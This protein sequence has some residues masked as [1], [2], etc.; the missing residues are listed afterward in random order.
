MDT[1]VSSRIETG[2]D[3]VPS[4][5]SV[6]ATPRL[7]QTVVT[8]STDRL[9]MDLKESIYQWAEKYEDGSVRDAVER[10]KMVMKN[11]IVKLSKQEMIILNRFSSYILQHNIKTDNFFYLFDMVLKP[12]DVLY[13]NAGYYLPESGEQIKIFCKMF[14][15]IFKDHIQYVNNLFIVEDVFPQN[16]VNGKAFVINTREQTVDMTLKE[17]LLVVKVA[18]TPESD[19]L[20]YEYYIGRFLNIMRFMGITDVFALMYGRFTCDFN[21]DRPGDKLCT[22]KS[23]DDKKKIHIITEYVRNVSTG[24]SLSLY[25][26]INKRF[27]KKD[28]LYT[29]IYKYLLETNLIVKN[30]MMM[31]LVS[32]QRA[33]DLM[34]FTHYDLHLGNILIVEHENARKYNTGADYFPAVK[35]MPHII[36]YGR[37]YIDTSRVLEEYKLL[38]DKREVTYVDDNEKK[39]TSF[40][41]IQKEIYENKKFTSNNYESVEIMV[42]RYISENI[43]EYINVKYKEEIE[44][45]INERKIHYKNLLEQEKD[46]QKKILE[47]IYEENISKDEKENRKRILKYAMYYGP[48][49][50]DKNEIYDEYRK[51]IYNEYRN[52]VYEKYV[53]SKKTGINDDQKKKFFPNGDTLK[54]GV[55]DDIY[56]LVITTPT[57]PNYQHDMFK[58]V[59]SICNHM[60]SRIEMIFNKNIL[61]DVEC[62]NLA[63][64]WIE[65]KAVLKQEFPIYLERYTL[66]FKEIDNNIKSP[67]MLVN[68]LNNKD[69]VMTGGAKNS[70]E[71]DIKKNEIKTESEND[72]KMHQ[73]KDVKDI[74]KM[75]Y[76]MVTEDEYKKYIDKE[77][78]KMI[79]EK[80]GTQMNDFDLKVESELKKIFKKK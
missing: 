1:M 56:E 2:T 54:Y 48:F 31:I 15:D 30:I 36:D 33:Q 69:K 45:K 75:Y 17:K 59:M 38:Y 63:K 78:Q 16:S 58:V 67:G 46:F 79:Q 29:E 43:D 71:G 51:I 13:G 60:I 26:F 28:M 42:Q 57:R 44:K 25:D 77:I 39:Y 68:Y 34:S 7:E 41:E 4:R 6:S 74:P 53:G 12:L 19:S 72:L 66:L 14:N 20:S 55:P 3:V 24:K 73:L 40:M 76:S 61:K 18:L 21:I 27:N 5:I 11:P 52:K 35:H 8:L 70:K 80:G 49:E 47:Y 32:L 62:S 65:T 64:E 37:C 22:K 9:L 10:F 23:E 50:K